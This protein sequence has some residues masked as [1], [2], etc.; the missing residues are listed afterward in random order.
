M[1]MFSE[2]KSTHDW[3]NHSI[4]K[5]EEEHWECANVFIILLRG[6]TLMMI[7][8][9]HYGDDDDGGDYGDGDDDGGDGDD[10]EVGALGGSH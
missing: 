6:R 9:F 2:T 7:F 3:P 4:R 8:V 5:I 1:S 10:D